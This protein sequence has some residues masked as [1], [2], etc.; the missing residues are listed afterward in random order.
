M[1]VR[2]RRP[3]S[4]SEGATIATAAQARS[5]A[6]YD[7]TPGATVCEDAT[8]SAPRGTE[9]A[10]RQDRWGELV[11]AGR[12]PDAWWVCAMRADESA[13][14]WLLRRVQYATQ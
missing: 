10:A 8:S 11:T 9:C 3:S 7:P 4:L 5:R 1:A 14:A 12:I 2:P 6:R 13:G